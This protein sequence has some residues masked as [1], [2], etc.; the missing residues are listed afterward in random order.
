MPEERVGKAE[1]KSN[2]YAE[3]AGQFFRKNLPFAFKRGSAPIAPL[4]K[5]IG[6]M[7]IVGVEQ[8]SFLQKCWVQLILSDG[9]PNIYY[10]TR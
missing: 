8:K 9:Y 3:S 6:S 10:R 2:R 4:W 5:I 1:W 7:L